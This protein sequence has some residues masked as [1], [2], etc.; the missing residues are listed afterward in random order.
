ML[1]DRRTEGR[2][3]ISIDEEVRTNGQQEGQRFPWESK[4]GQT[5]RRKERNFH[6]R[7]R[8]N[9]RTTGRTEIPIEEQGWI[10]G[11]KEGQR[12]PYRRV[13]TNLLRRFKWKTQFIL[14][15]KKCN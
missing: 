13:R 7:A 4:D 14:R 2:T 12:F 8:T 5:Y 3:E 11:Q 9:R 6:R 15:V 1:T 10:D